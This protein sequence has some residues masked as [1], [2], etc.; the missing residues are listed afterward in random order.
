[1]CSGASWQQSQTMASAQSHCGACN[2]ETAPAA[3]ARLFDPGSAQALTSCPWQV[4][5]ASQALYTRTHRVLAACHRPPAKTLAQAL[6]CNLHHCADCAP[7]ACHRVL[8]TTRNR[9][10]AKTH[11][12]ASVWAVSLVHLTAS[13]TCLSAVQALSKGAMAAAGEADATCWPCCMLLSH[14]ELT[15]R[16]YFRMCV[17]SDF[18]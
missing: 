18:V 3:D 17:D 13:K 14:K 15:S 9:W 12:K 11:T 4:M 1:M 2:P 10:T 5:R 6:Q 8:A 7:A 16:V